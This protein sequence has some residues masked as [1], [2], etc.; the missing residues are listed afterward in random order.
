MGQC[1]ITGWD[2]ECCISSV[3]GGHLGTQT[4]DRAMSAK[5]CAL[6]LIWDSLFS[7]IIGY[8]DNVKEPEKKQ[9]KTQITGSETGYRCKGALEVI[10]SHCPAQ[11]GSPGA[12]CPGLCPDAFWIS[13]SWETPQFF[14]ATCSAAH[15]HN[16]KKI[17]SWCSDCNSYI[18]TC[19]LWSCYWTALKRAELC[20]LCTL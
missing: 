12:H 13:L 10:W 1:W 9:E 17:F 6:H 16:K 14:W 3:T 19:A 20:P 18:S 2:W 7:G 5:P 4:G 8:S 15:H 11:V